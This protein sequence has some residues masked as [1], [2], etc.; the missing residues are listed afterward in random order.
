MNSNRSQLSSSLFTPTGGDVVGPISSLFQQQPANPMQLPGLPRLPNTAD[1]TQLPDP[2]YP[3]DVGKEPADGKEDNLNRKADLMRH[4]LPNFG[5]ADDGKPKRVGFTLGANQTT[6]TQPKPSTEKPRP[7]PSTEKSQLEQSV[8][9][10]QTK[11]STA[12]PA[13]IFTREKLLALSNAMDEEDRG[14]KSTRKPR[15]G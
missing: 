6:T 11:P 2:L 9:T 7:K 12:K 14:A 15:R 3:L 8:E 13:T 5:A 4:W 1:S 10:P